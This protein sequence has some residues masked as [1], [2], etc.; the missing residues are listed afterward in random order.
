LKRGLQ[1]A[2]EAGR[3]PSFGPIIACR[4]KQFQ[5]RLIGVYS[6]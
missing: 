4:K 2:R 1:A 3:V 5:F 6:S